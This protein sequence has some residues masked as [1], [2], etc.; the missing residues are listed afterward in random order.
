MPSF[1]TAGFGV[2]EVH[3]APVINVRITKASE[4]TAGD[5]GHEGRHP[6]PARDAT[7]V[8][9][10]ETEGYMVDNVSHVTS[11]VS[12]DVQIEVGNYF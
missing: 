9:E 11:L 1:L 5:H 7:D 12:L 8:T 6:T 2:R 4:H 10:R 3:N